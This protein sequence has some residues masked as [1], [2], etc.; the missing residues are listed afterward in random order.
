MFAPIAARFV[1]V[2]TEGWSRGMTILT[3]SFSALGVSVKSSKDQP[4]RVRPRAGAP[5]RPW[6]FPM[7]DG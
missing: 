3:V 4:K 2:D 5:S 7:A 1:L 6:C